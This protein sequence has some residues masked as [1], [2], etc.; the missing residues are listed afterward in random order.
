[1]NFDLIKNLFNLDVNVEKIADFSKDITQVTNQT[2]ENNIQNV[3]VIAQEQT[4]SDE[5]FAAPPEDWL[6]RFIEG[7][8][9]AS[10]QEAQMIWAHILCRE[11]ERPGSISFRTMEILKSLDKEIADLFEKFCSLCYERYLDNETDTQIGVPCLEKHAGDNCLA[12][13]GLEYKNLIKLAECG[14]ISY[15][16]N[17]WTN[18]IVIPLC[19]IDYVSLKEPFFKFQNKIWTLQKPEQKNSS[20]KIYG[21]SA[22]SAGGELFNVIS[23]NPNPKFEEHVKNRL[24]SKGITMVESVQKRSDDAR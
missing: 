3:F 24:I 18:F 17:A 11:S 16:L 23:P 15:E 10:R 9:F 21:L 8:K 5:K 1:M 12:E 7:A 19:K 13:Y 4:S 14:L 22:S 20:F 6:L 2:Q